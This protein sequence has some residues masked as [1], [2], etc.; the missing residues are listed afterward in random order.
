M[1]LNETRFKYISNFVYCFQFRITCTSHISKPNPKIF[2]L[3]LFFYHFLLFFWCKENFAIFVLLFFEISR[4]T[5]FFLSYIQ[6]YIKIFVEFKY[7][8]FFSFFFKLF[9]LTN[10][11]YFFF[12]FYLINFFFRI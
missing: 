5:R 9:K 3:G 6:E 4:I 1:K 2:M 8:Y 7:K 11:H 10:V 12:L